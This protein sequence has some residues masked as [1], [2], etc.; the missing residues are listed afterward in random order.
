[1]AFSDSVEKY[2]VTKVDYN[3]RGPTAI[4]AVASE[5]DH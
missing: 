4:Y 3:A 2:C 1:M 5:D